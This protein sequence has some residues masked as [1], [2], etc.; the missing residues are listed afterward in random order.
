MISVFEAGRRLSPVA[1]VQTLEQLSRYVPIIKN[2]NDAT[3]SEYLALDSVVGIGTTSVVLLYKTKAETLE[4]SVVVKLVKK[5]RGDFTTPERE[6]ALHSTAAQY[7]VAPELVAFHDNLQGGFSALVMEPMSVSLSTYLHREVIDVPLVARMLASALVTLYTRANLTHGDLHT[8]NI[9]LDMDGDH[10]T[11]L[12]LIDFGQATDKFVAPPLDVATVL[13]SIGIS[14]NTDVQLAFESTLNKMT[15]LLYEDGK[16]S[17]V[18][19]GAKYSKTSADDY[20]ELYTQYVQI[21]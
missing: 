4:Q 17:G 3:A 7:G 18:I 20:E 19:K 11:R 8:G 14:G 2:V 21:K 1:D 10:V 16:Q 5:V 6:S 12:L 15:R 13:K 9:M